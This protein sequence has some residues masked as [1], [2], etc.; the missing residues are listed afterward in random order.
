MAAASAVVTAA[1]LAAPTVVDLVAAAVAD[2]A[3]VMQVDLP[4][5]PAA[6]AAAAW[7]LPGAHSIIPQ[8]VAAFRMVR[9]MI[10]VA[11]TITAASTSTRLSASATIA[12]GSG[13]ASPTAITRG[14]VITILGGGTTIPRLTTMTTIRI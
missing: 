13:A 2:S 4:H 3:A 1:D 8:W 10:I 11:I 14:G 6:F 5:T 9:S 7:V 12:L